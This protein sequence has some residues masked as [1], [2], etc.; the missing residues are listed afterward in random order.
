MNGLTVLDVLGALG[1][2]VYSLVSPCVA[3]LIPVY[4][5]YISGVSINPDGTLARGSRDLG[6]VVMSC[7][8]FVLGFTFVFVLLGSSAGFVS[9]FLKDH[10]DLVNQV[11]G[12]FMIAMGLLMLGMLR[13][14]FLMREWR[15]NVNPD[16]FGPAGP[17]LFGMAFA[18]AWTPCIGPVLGAILL[19]AS[20]EATA[21]SGGIL[22]LIYSMGFGLPFILAGVAWSQGVQSF[23][24]LSRHYSLLTVAGAAIIIVT[25]IFFFTGQS[26]HLNSWALQFYDWIGDRYHQLLTV[27]LA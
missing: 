17:V 4:M 22:L 2:G 27:A 23:G 3:P 18:F 20:T 7:L 1:A 11:S 13:I 26:A 16:L 10:R 8:L 5:A 25:G 12:V 19:K 14:P 24:F 15:P 6:H 9:E 21:G